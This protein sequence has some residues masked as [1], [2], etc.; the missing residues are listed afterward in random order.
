MIGII[1]LIITILLIYLAYKAVKWMFASGAAGG[2]NI[3]D[4]QPQASIDEDLIEDPCCH[5]YIPLSQAHKVERDGKTYYFCSRDC[6][7]KYEYND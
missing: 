2:R 6:A 1:R 3:R 5:R 7:D 4:N